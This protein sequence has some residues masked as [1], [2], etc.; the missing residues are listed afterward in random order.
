MST[1][2][3]IEGKSRTNP[4]VDTVENGPGLGFMGGVVIDM[5][6][7]ERGRLGRLLTA[8]AQH[9][10]HLGIG[11]D[12]NTAVVVDGCHFQ[13][14]G[15]GAVTII[16]ASHLSYSNLQEL[17]QDQHALALCDICLHNLPSGYEFDLQQR[18]PIIP[19][20]LNAFVSKEE[21]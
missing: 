15:Q 3:I 2:M 8:V 1:V 11:I 16:D 21:H 12:E 18:R 17:G 9:P 19:L 4:A 14:I 5:H 6:F 13:V 20:A 10:G 7:A